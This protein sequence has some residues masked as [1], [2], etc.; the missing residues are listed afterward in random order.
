VNSLGDG[1]QS[2]G[3]AIPGPKKEIAARL[4]SASAASGEDTPKPPFLQSARAGKLSNTMAL[5]VY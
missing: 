5:P 1:P 4:V 3:K 2:L